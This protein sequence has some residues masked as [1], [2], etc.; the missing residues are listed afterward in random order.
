MQ[1]GLEEVPL[2]IRGEVKTRGL[3]LSLQTW[4]VESIP[5]C[6]CL[7]VCLSISPSVVDGV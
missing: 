3:L 1:K 6:L 5:L 2:A 4:Q 7:S